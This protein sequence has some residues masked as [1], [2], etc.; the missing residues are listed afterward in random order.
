MTSVD[1]FHRQLCSNPV[2]TQIGLR[3]L[4]F[5]DFYRASLASA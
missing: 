2:V 3:R 5:C 4:A 1:P